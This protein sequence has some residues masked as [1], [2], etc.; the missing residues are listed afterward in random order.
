MASS[1]DI[2]QRTDDWFAVRCGKAT[3]SKIADIIAKTKSGYSA[4]RANYMA[5]L[6][7]ERLTGTPT[8]GFTNAA[9]QWGVDHE[10]EACSAYAFHYDAELATV[11]FVNHPHI[12]MSGASPDRLV[13]N[14]GLAEIKCPNSATH[15][16]TLLTGKVPEK[17]V[18][19]MMWQ[20][21]C[22]DRDWC[23][24]VSYDPRLPEEM[25]LFVQRIN[26]DADRIAELEGEVAGF[27]SDVADT[28][29]SLRA[30]FSPI[31][32]ESENLIKLVRAG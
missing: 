25:R 30:K 32:P 31:P 11:G 2:I 8:E 24:F 28:V 9:M 26:R 4:S 21:A 22:C 18:T 23:D 16:D 17:Y 19:Q 7:C 10:D 15:I 5:Q 1:Y 29:E 13:G 3:A 14:R 12:D 6:V 20:M 27:L